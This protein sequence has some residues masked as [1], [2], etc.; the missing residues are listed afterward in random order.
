MTYLDWPNE[1]GNGY[2]MD[3]YKATGLAE[4]FVDP[5]SDDPKAE[6]T[7]AWQYLHDTGLAYKLQ[8]SFGRGAQHLIAEGI[9]LP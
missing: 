5:V 3:D 1:R 9:I 7:A 4:G 8:G 2:K 6:I